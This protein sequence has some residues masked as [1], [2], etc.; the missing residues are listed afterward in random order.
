MRISMRFGAWAVMA[1]AVAASASAQDKVLLTFSPSSGAL[2]R[3]VLNVNGKA[4]IEGQALE[5][6][7]TDESETKASSVS[8]G[9]VTT[10]SKTVSSII[11]VN[12]EEQDNEVSGNVV[13]AV[14][15]ANGALQK[16][17]G[18][19]DDD[20][21]GPRLGQ[22]FTLVFADKP[23]G[24][25]DTWTYSY[26]RASK[27][28]GLVAADFSAKLVA[29]DG[30]SEEGL[31]QIEATYKE[32]DTEEKMSVTMTAWVDPTTGVIKKSEFKIIGM[33]LGLPGN[34]EFTGSMELKSYKAAADAT[35]DTTAPAQ[36]GEGEE[37]EGDNIDS[38]VE[39]FTKMDGLFP[40]Y[41][42]EED[43]E[44]TIYM[45]IKR[46]QLDKW[47]MLQATAA[48]GTSSQVVMGD[49]L[50]DL[51]FQFREVQPGR[52]TVVV[53]NYRLIADPELPIANIIANSFAPSYLDTFDIEATQ[54]DRDSVLIDVSDFFKGDV[55]GIEAR[56]QGGG[57][58]L[59]GGGA[60]YSLDRDNTF[61]NTIKNFPLNTVV[62]STYT[63]ADG[64]A[65]T[66]VEA[67]LFGGG[68]NADPRSVV[69][70]VNYNLYQ[71][72]EN[73][74]FVPRLF[75]ERVGYFTATLE[76]FSDPTSQD[77]RVKHVLR[78]NLRKA[79]PSQAVSDPVEPI[80]FYLDKGIPEEFRK[81]TRDGILLWNEPMRAAGFSNAIV[82]KDMP[83]DA[84]F[85]HADMRYNTI[86]FV[87][88]PDAAY[89][90]ALFRVNP[91]TGQ[92][93]NSSIT[94]DI[95]YLSFEANSNEIAQMMARRAASFLGIELPE[96]EKK[97]QRCNVCGMSH[98]GQLMRATG[99]LEASS[100]NEEERER[101]LYQAVRHTVAHEFGHILG[102]RHNFVASTQLTFAQMN[103]PAM[104]AK[105]GT[106]AS[107][108][109]Y[110]PY[111]LNAVNNPNVPYYAELGTYDKWAIRWGYSDVPGTTAD[112]EAGALR[113]IANQGVQEGFAYRT[114]QH[115]D[116]FD[117][118]VQRFDLSKNPMDYSMAMMTRTKKL[119]TELRDKEPKNGEN[120]SQ[121]TNRFG[122]LVNM[123]L[124]AAFS[125]VSFIGGVEQRTAIRGT[126]SDGPTSIP[127]SA[128][129]QR[130]ALRLINENI[131]AAGA[132][133]FP[134]D[135][136]RYFSEDLRDDYGLASN[137][138]PWNVRTQISGFPQM[139]LN[140]V[141][142]SPTLERVA[143]NEYKA[144]PGEERFTV[145]EL[146]GTLTRSL[147]T[148][149]PA[150]QAV[151]P[152]RREL[153]TAYVTRLIDLGVKGAPGGA[154]EA[155]FIARAHLKGV[156]AVFKANQSKVKD[157]TTSLYVADMI[158][159]IERNLNA[160]EVL[161]AG[162]GGGG[163]DL[164]QMLLGGRKP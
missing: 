14:Q 60:S 150:G 107:V 86:R 25:G 109:D 152:I 139:F 145:S 3:S 65:P 83:E 84:D 80:V 163:G 50:V 133:D 146:F 58:G 23:V 77:R 66:G 79:N 120:Y 96:A 88:S 7:I 49:P 41:V 154:S 19:E 15:G 16:Q 6:S 34:P 17:S 42:K 164:L 129:Q 123:H 55:A 99:M 159:R 2:W 61:V 9:S 151:D 74:G 156:L 136:F 143:N 51:L 102:L 18:F 81:A 114:D 39:D 122:N 119:I 12:G 32:R 26:P 157:E 104:V 70:N 137:P 149:L 134:K 97:T 40:L 37:E 124:S 75:D 158:E 130:A 103:D 43:G 110:V 113:A 135:L 142:S 89:A 108:M 5:F 59:F 126:S 24:V 162:G 11:S 62:R 20:D 127:V 36:D 13:K 69:V 35:V 111:N 31:A 57:G 121:L 87:A 72:P 53:P 155:N 10:E 46:S 144:L 63:F 92:I 118:F 161:G 112:A 64:N 4:T 30:A 100:V 22:A 82:V 28:D 138:N 116:S 68:V 94:F 105:Y 93:M 21:L 78:W 95:N 117:P 54:K 140:M 1:L 44:K 33:P 48:S 90:V 56:F 73:N 131:F 52:L 38:T 85:D 91:L 160:Q 141:L 45:E 98:E 148:E 153:Q 147:F 29:F 8:D 125:V 101:Y 27:S 132:L 106:T 67:G 71:M 115:A 76:D 47:T 128:G